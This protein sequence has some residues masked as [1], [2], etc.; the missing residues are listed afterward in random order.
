MMCRV[1]YVLLRLIFFYITNVY[2]YTIAIYDD[3]TARHHREESFRPEWRVKQH[4]IGSHSLSGAGMGTLLISKVRDE[5]P[6]RMMC[7]YSVV[8]SPK[9]SDNVVEVKTITY[10][11]PILL[12]YEGQ[13]LARQCSPSIDLLKTQTKVS[14]SIM[15]PS[16]IYFR[17]LKLS[18]P[19]YGDLNHL[20][21]RRHAYAHPLQLPI[22]TTIS[23]LW[24]N[25]IGAWM[26]KMMR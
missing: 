18:T 2:L 11:R 4:M 20:V 3:A 22:Y 17:T 14:A 19:T 8:P 13:L 24:T 10:F 7:T 1:R 15:R 23:R 21:S 6:D 16:D 12:T 25:N 9:V 26:E 5:Y